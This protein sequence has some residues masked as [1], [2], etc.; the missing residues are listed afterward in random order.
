MNPS[1]VRLFLCGRNGDSMKRGIVKK[2]TFEIEYPDGTTKTSTLDASVGLGEV[3]SIIFDDVCVPEQDRPIWN[4]SEDWRK[5]PTMLLRK[6]NHNALS[7]PWCYTSSC[8]SA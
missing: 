1:I 2:V 6:K 4:A 8:P 5:N 7:V 3:S